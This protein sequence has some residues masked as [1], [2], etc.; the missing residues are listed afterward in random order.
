[1]KKIFIIL[2]LFGLSCSKLLCQ[3][4]PNIPNI[5]N[6]NNSNNYG[7]TDP[8]TLSLFDPLVGYIR[9]HEVD[10]VIADLTKSGT[11][12]E[13]RQ[14]QTLNFINDEINF[15]Q[16]RKDSV[17]K[18]PPDLFF[19]LAGITS[20]I[21]GIVSL[22]LYM[23]NRELYKNDNF[24]KF[25]LEHRPQCRSWCR[26]N[27]TYS[28]HSE[29]FCQKCESWNTA[30]FYNLNSDEAQCCKYAGFGLPIVGYLLYKWAKKCPIANFKLK[31]LQNIEY[32]VKLL[33]NK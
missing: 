24:N 7:F 17:L 18:S 27:W 22:H 9:R 28:Y 19:T 8:N 33:S 31:K 29:Y 12:D 30:Q 11:V 25:R 3:Y 2:A 1:M 13:F 16:N 6:V 23:V 32:F 15:W 10:N 21:V 5:P 4:G 26:N 20:G 14:R